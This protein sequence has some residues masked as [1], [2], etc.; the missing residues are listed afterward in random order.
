MSEDLT[1]R[2]P[3]ASGQLAGRVVATQAL[4]PRTVDGMWALF[5][6][7]YAEVTREHFERDLFEKRDVIVLTDTGDG[8][9]Q[10]FST[11][12]VY[13]RRVMGRRVVAVFSGDTIVHQDYWGQTALQRTFLGYI[14]RTKLKHPFV[15]VYWYLI[16][17]GYK[18]YLLL[19]RNYLEY[20]PR[21]DKATPAWQQ[22]VIDQ[23]S[24]DRYGDAYD[25]SS[26]VLRFA[27]DDGR[28]RDGVSPIDRELLEAPD[29]RFFVERN[30]GH[31]EG[32][33]LCCIGRVNLSLWAAYTFKLLK[34]GLGFAPRRKAAT[35]P[36]RP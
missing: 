30:P 20:W 19:S 31:S 25:A 35:S 15:P 24:R 3:L 9:L 8:S 36:S 6:L 1:M 22:A 14:M 4:D 23:L 21:H 10:G 32:E 18:T 2:A 28:L 12:L 34:R 26:G 13:D 7:Y 29:I 17:K 5:R 33:E 16:S 11:L 27:G